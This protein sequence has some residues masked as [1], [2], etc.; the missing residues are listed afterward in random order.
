MSGYRITT[1]NSKGKDVDQTEVDTLAMA[2]DYAINF[3]SDREDAFGEDREALKRYG[4]IDAEDQA[5]AIGDDG[6]TVH[7]P[8]G[9]KIVIAPNNSD[10][11][12]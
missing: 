1:Y 11:K 2:Q 12:E 9:W 5:L 7:L 10:D 4:Y 3:V 8:D 6:G